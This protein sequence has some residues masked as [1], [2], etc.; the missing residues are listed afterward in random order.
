MFRGPVV[1]LECCGTNE[2]VSEDTTYSVPLAQI[3]DSVGTDL[4]GHLSQ[5][6]HALYS[7]DANDDHVCTALLKSRIGVLIRSKCFGNVSID[8]LA[9]V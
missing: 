3:L 5:D 7:C 8:V 4:D 2:C 1:Q 6:G 9:V